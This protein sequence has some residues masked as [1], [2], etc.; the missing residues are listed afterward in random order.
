NQICL[1]GSLD[2]TG[3]EY[4][5][6]INFADQ[7]LTAINLK[8]CPNLKKLDLSNNSNLNELDLSNNSQLI[9]LDLEGIKGIEELDISHLTNL[10]YLKHDKDVKVFTFLDKYEREL[11]KEDLNNLSEILIKKI[12]DQLK[13]I[14]ESSKFLRTKDSY[15]NNN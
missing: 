14:S 10:L 3:F 6:E 5:E 12:N 4:L 7:N 2:L 8:D 13:F 9:Y 11:I 1:E 15:Q